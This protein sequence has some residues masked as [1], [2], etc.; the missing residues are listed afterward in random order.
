MPE[1]QPPIKHQCRYCA[2]FAADI[3]DVELRPDGCNWTQAYASRVCGKCRKYLQ[4]RF[5]YP[6]R[7]ATTK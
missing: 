2:K 4:G 3:V 7:K 1:S 6:N 5:R